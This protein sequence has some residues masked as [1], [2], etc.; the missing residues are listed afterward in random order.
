MLTDFQNSFTVGL[1][2]LE[3][4]CS[5]TCVNV[6]HVVDLGRS[7]WAKVRVKNGRPCGSVFWD[8]NL[9]VVAVC[10]TVWVF[11]GDEGVSDPLETRPSR[12]SVTTAKLVVLGQAVGA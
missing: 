8:G 10:Q 6:P 11:I 4:R 7:E 9:T 2:F 1:C 12:T 5:P 3:T